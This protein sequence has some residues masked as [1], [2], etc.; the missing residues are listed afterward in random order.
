MLGTATG[1][2]CGAR[3]PSHP[4]LPAWGP[5]TTTPSLALYI[6]T[7]Q[8]VLQHH[9]LQATASSP[10]RPNAMQRTLPLLA[11]LLLASAAGVHPSALADLMQATGLLLDRAL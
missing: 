5:T 7:L 11:A 8:L 10:A 3:S 2:S 4:R 1:P 6:H 9:T